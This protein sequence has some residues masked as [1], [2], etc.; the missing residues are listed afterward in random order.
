MNDWWKKAIVYQI[1]PRSFKD[2]NGDGIGDLKG[3]TSKI[4]Y[5]KSL[6]VDVI[7][8]SPHFQ[9]PNADNGYDISDYQAV[10]ADFGTMEDFDEM[11]AAIHQNDMKL[12]IDLVVNHSSDEH[13]WFQEARKSKDN[14]YRDYYIWKPE[15]PNDWISFFS[16]NAW[17]L[18]P[19][20]NEYY[21]HL[22]LKKQ[23]D[24][25]WE[26][27]K[28]RQEVYSLMR[29]WLDKGVDGFRMDVISVISKDLSFPNFPEGRFGD[30]NFYANGP[31]VHEYLQEMNREVLS[32]YD[33]M[34]VGE[35]FGVTAEQ[36]NQ[37]V[38]KDRGEL[39]MI[40]HFEHAVPRDEHCFV[41]PSAEFK[42][43]EL[44]AIFR[45]W[46]SAVGDDGWNTVYFGNHD[47]PRVISRFGDTEKYR[48]QSAKM[49]ATILLTLRGT[50]Y[51]YQG[52]EIGMSNC[53]FESINEFEDVQVRNA[54]RALV[55]DGKNSEKA[56]LKASN[57]I[58]RDHARTP[59]QWNKTK[60]GGF[61]EGKKTWLKVNPN[62]KQVNVEQQ[63]QDPDSVLNYYRALIILRKKTD[64]LIYGEYIDLRPNC[65]RIWA[66]L[67]QM[68]KDKYL[69]INNFTDKE[70]EFNLTYL[71]SDLSFIFGNYAF[72][73]SKVHGKKYKLRPYE[74]QIYSIKKGSV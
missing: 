5:L 13:R 39:N 41:K 27:P 33:C 14:L 66:Y 8:L 40:Y 61:T 43:N 59:M 44:K 9:S 20:T 11:L 72:K 15:I 21:L 37:Y 60:F 19:L 58:A 30:L 64:A 68:G 38:G 34:T 28:L 12:I 2:S 23:P 63:E 17:E 1:Y 56:F 51:L 49:I 45:K 46:D 54:Y 47:N 57:Y 70:Q 42:L 24:L 48:K 67:R 55:V 6:G 52:D 25:N 31:R 73:E 36:A 7:W 65:N 53:A 35:A 50:P 16:G 3:I 62:Y 74:S 69:I 32:Q 10:M 71:S 26:N 18:D 29:F 22:F 4:D